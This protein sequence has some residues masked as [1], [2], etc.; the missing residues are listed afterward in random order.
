MERAV[1]VVGCCGEARRIRPDHPRRHS[2]AWAVVAIAIPAGL[3]I[4]RLDRSRRGWSVDVLLFRSR[5]RDRKA[6]GPQS[7]ATTGSSARRGESAQG[8]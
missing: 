2:G 3:A 8:G 6:P 7:S 5:Q 4:M 1:N